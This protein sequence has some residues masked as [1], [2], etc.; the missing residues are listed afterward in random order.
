[1]GTT[2]GATQ[3]RLKF[4]GATWGTNVDQSVSTLAPSNTRYVDVAAL[5]SQVNHRLYRQGR[6]YMVRVGFHKPGV[7]VGATVSALPN[8]W[9]T[10]KAWVA[11]RK[12]Y[13]KAMRD[14]GVKKSGRWNDFRVNYDKAQYLGNSS[15]QWQFVTLSGAS[16]SEAERRVTQVAGDSGTTEGNTTNI[17]QFHALGATDF[18]DRDGATASFG[19]IAEYNE[20]EDTTV[21]DPQDH[22]SNAS[23]NELNVDSAMTNTNAEL[24]IESG[25]YPPYDPDELDESRSVDYVIRQ[26][27]DDSITPTTPWIAAP[28]GLLKITGYGGGSLEADL[29]MYVEVMAG[30]YKGVMSETI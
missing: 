28:M 16:L 19:L 13:L 25:D 21:N 24:A 29:D 20:Q 17:Y 18:S 22:G 15:L 1:M 7:T 12:A 8:T 27:A 3:L 9:M 14:S 4:S 11:G 2:A 26:H 23:Y 5:L 30:G 10:R 6:M